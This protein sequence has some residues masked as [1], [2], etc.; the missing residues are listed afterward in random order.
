MNAIIAKAW[1][2]LLIALLCF[3]NALT[4]NLYINE[5]AAHARDQGKSEQLAVD[6]QAIHDFWEGRYK[7]NLNAAKTKFEASLPAVRAGA[8]NAY[9]LRNPTMCQPRACATEGKPVDDATNGAGVPS[10]PTFI[11]QCAE[12]QSKLMQFQ[13]VCG[14]GNCEVTNE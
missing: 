4:L 1:P 9:C 3:L 12:A 10:D 14:G 7:E 13:D 6:S 11:R 2:Y 5:R 8:V